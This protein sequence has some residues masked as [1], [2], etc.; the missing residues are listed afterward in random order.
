MMKSIYD[1]LVGEVEANRFKW[2]HEYSLAFEAIIRDHNQELDEQ[3]LQHLRMDAIAFRFMTRDTTKDKKSERIQPS[4]VFTDGS[5]FPDI[6]KDLT[7]ETFDYYQKRLGECTNPTMRLRYADI[8]WEKDK[9][10]KSKLILARQLAAAALEASNVFDHDNELERVD[11]LNRALQ[12]SLAIGK[13]GEELA[14]TVAAAVTARLKKLRDENKI[15]FTLELIETIINFHKQFTKD[16]FTLCKEICEVAIKH[17]RDENNNFML[18]GAFVQRGYELDKLLDPASYDQK[19]AVR[20]FAQTRIEEAERRTDSLLVQQ[21]FLR[22]AHKILQDAGLN[23]EAADLLKRI[24]AL[25]KDEHFDNQFKPFSTTYE[26]P[27]EVI[28]ALED[29]VRQYSDTA[30]LIAISPNFISKWSEAENAANKDTNNYISDIFPSARYDDNGMVIAVSGG[31]AAFNKMMRYFQINIEFKLAHLSTMLRKLIKESAITAS[32]FSTQFDKLR[33]IDEATHRSILYGLRL[34]LEGGEDNFYAAS[35][36]LTTQLED[37]MFRLL[38]I[39]EV[40]QYIAEKDGQTHSPKT[41]GWFLKEMKEA[42]GDDIYRLCDYTLID[43]AH[44]NIR[45]EIGHGKT[46]ITDDNEMVCVRILQII[47]IFCV[48]LNVNETEDA[49]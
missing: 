46:K 32:N 3:Q 23:K 25:G 26:I 27:S 8:L 28:D 13:A 42:I 48:M 21:S 19:A 9:R 37:L 15:R 17:Y 22:E 14:K 30:E 39:M 11:C 43:K 10:I 16:D 5:T 35:L 47:S 18:R 49:E 2:D 20:G 29:L 24:E 38:P 6:A 31:D 33:H 1:K 4:V 44:L 40:T 36:I 45:N 7:D 34:F 41:I 12:V